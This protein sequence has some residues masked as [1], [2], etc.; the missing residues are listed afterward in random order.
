[1][2]LRKTGQYPKSMTNYGAV[3]NFTMK[4]ELEWWNRSNLAASSDRSLRHDDIRD[5]Q[6]NRPG[7]LY[8]SASPLSCL[9]HRSILRSLRQVSSTM[10]SSHDQNVSEPLDSQSQPR[11]S[12]ASATGS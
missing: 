2:A 6:G 7:C 11:F 10:S 3:G 4:L 9:D 1:M 5:H 12:S 8:G